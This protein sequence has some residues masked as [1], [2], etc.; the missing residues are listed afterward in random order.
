METLDHFRSDRRSGDNRFVFG[1]G[2]KR[3]HNNNYKKLI[4]SHAGS[5]TATTNYKEKYSAKA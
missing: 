3:K 4:I 1:Y 5:S 2:L